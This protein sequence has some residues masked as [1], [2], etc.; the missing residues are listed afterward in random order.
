MKSLNREILRLAVPSILA[1]ITVP[2]VGMVDIAIAGHLHGIPSDAVP[3][4]FIGAVSV[5]SLL[6]TVLYWNFG[7]LRAGTGGLTAQAYGRSKA[8]DARGTDSP[9][10]ILGRGLVLAVGCSIIILLLQWPFAKLGL[11]L[12]GGTPE[13]SRLAGRYFFIR[14]WA[15]PATLS[16]MVLRGWFIGMQDTRSSMW[17]DLIVNGT[18][19]AASLLLAFPLGVG[20][21]GIALGTVIAQYSGLAFALA[22]VE[23]RYGGQIRGLTFKACMSGTREFFSLNA[24]L[25]FRSLCFMLIYFGFSAIAA[26]YGDMALAVASIMMNLLMLFSYFTDGFAYAGEALT[27]RFMGEKDPAML[28]MSVRYIFVWSMAVAFLWVAI[29]LLAGAPLLKLMTDDP[30]VRESARAFLPWLALMPPLGCAAFTWD[31][32]YTGA[33]STK[34]MRNSMILAAIAFF[35]LWFAGCSVMGLAPSGNPSAPLE[36][37]AMNLLL[38]AYFAHLLARTVWLSLRYRKDVLSKCPYFS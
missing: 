38:A 21:D 37:G 36:A 7:F 31:G 22:V 11:L 15:A 20:F 8:G 3:A 14:I 13:V 33:T 19:I 16:L 12:I 35:G 25:F 6:F 23:K 2:L 1:N 17:A 10:L 32:I 24:D 27:G 5:G 34:E 18:N 9:G 29:Y 4:A 26:R 30:T 28:R